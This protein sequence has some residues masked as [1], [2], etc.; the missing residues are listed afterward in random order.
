[1]TMSARCVYCGMRLD[2]RPV[3][4]KF[5][6]EAL[7]FC[8]QRCLTLF[9]AVGPKGKMKARIQSER[10]DILERLEAK[11]GSRVLTLVHRRE[12][13]SEEEGGF[14]TIEDTEALVAQI[15]RTPADEPVDLI[16]H[17]PGGIAL[18]AEMIAMALRKRPGKVTAIVPFYAMSGGSLIALAA[19]EILMEKGSI[20]GPLDPQIAGFP[21]R[22]LIT[23][24]GRKPIETVSDQMVVLS[25]I[26]QRSV[27]QT[28]EFVKWLLED[29]LPPKDREAVAVFLTGGYIS[30]DTPIVAEVLRNLGLKVREGVPDEVYELFRTYEF[31]MCERPQCAAY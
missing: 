31:G 13:W 24:P 10:F 21:S 5:D 14:I 15:R 1:M 16:I 27:D 4:A 25:E 20:L 3:R 8:S 7:P 26:A 30:H 29:R 23:L 9:R 28:R 18:A 6:G 11:R 22:S 12:P 2:E 17:T 19:Q